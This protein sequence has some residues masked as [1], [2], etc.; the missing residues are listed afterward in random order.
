MAY[1][2]VEPRQF[3][4]SPVFRQEEFL[5]GIAGHDWQQYR[6]RHILVRGCSDIITPP[7]AYMAIASRLSGVARSVRY[8]NEHDNVVVSR[9]D[10]DSQKA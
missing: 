9:T 8:G 7:W 4:N 3:L 1:M 10:G 2:I 6:D 5:D